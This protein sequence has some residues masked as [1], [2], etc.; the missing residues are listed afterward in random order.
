MRL[1][2]SKFNEKKFFLRSQLYARAYVRIW[3]LRPCVREDRCV[4][5]DW[6]INKQVNSWLGCTICKECELTHLYGLKTHSLIKIAVFPSKF[7]EHSYGVM[8]FFNVC[9]FFLYTWLTWL[10]PA[11]RNLLYLA[12]QLIAVFAKMAWF[13]SYCS[14]L[15]CL[16]E[17]VRS[18]LS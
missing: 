13:N 16:F 15:P 6:K 9:Y 10:T 7:A 8:F 4:T 17:A 11:K 18:F 2:A 5:R 3:T 12:A 14:H 1:S